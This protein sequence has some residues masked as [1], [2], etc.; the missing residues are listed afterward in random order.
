MR[1]AVNARIARTAATTVAVAAAWL[2]AAG[3]AA[4]A[5]AGGPT[6]VLLVVPGGGGTAA[7]YYDE[8]E[9]AELAR[10][11]G[12]DGESDPVRDATGGGHETGS[13]VTVTWLIH[14]VQVWRV[15]RIYLGGPDGP[16]V[17]SQVRYDGDIWE[18]P[19][20]WYRPAQPKALLA[21]LERLGLDPTGGDGGIP[22]TDAQPAPEPSPVE[23]DAALAVQQE[24]PAPDR[25]TPWLLLAVAALTGALVAV[26]ATL[27][28]ARRAGIRTGKAVGATAHDEAVTVVETPD[29]DTH[30][31][32]A[33]WS[34]AEELVTRP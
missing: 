11:I 6:S 28:L 13:A 16:W 33:G 19:V 30:G 26:A 7:L 9:Y 22:L 14:D 8:P 21:L 27:P 25:D 2:L 23:R 31:T 12:A 20:S 4:P 15:D 3:L 29:V 18:V 10:L 34:P 5:Q 1:P 17:A 24:T 32:D